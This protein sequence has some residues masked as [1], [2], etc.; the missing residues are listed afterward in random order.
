MDLNLNLF[1]LQRC[2]KRTIFKN[3]EKYK[4]IS[5]LEKKNVL[6]VCFETLL[7]F[8]NLLP[9]PFLIIM[10]PKMQRTWLPQTNYKHS[11]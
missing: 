10:N 7:F 6:I 2:C 4:S 11:S 8:I 1:Q 5:I 9:Y 3:L